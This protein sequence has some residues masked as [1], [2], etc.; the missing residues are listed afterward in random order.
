MCGGHRVPGSRAGGGGAVR[1]ELVLRQHVGPE[2][3]RLGQKRMARAVHFTLK[4]SDSLAETGLAFVEV[5][6][7]NPKVR[8][9]PEGQKRQLRF[10]HWKLSLT[11]S[12]RAVENSVGVTSPSAVWNDVAPARRT[13]RGLVPGHLSKWLKEDCET[14]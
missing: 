3:L 4:T 11:F 6:G 9:Y 1:L 2:V 14:T 12:P 13:G 8:T 5:G 10:T 7:L